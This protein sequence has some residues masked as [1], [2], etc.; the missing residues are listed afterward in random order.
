LAPDW[1]S[2]GDYQPLYVVSMGILVKPRLVIVRFSI[3]GLRL[4][5]AVGGLGRGAIW[6]NGAAR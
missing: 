3:H 4:L 1:K 6:R 2:D 5:V